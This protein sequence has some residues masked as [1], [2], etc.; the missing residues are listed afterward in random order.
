MEQWIPSLAI[1]AAGQCSPYS[2]APSCRECRGLIKETPQSDHSWDSLVVCNTRHFSCFT[3]LLKSSWMQF[4]SR[5]LW[6][7]SLLSPKLL[8][9]NVSSFRRLIWTLNLNSSTP[10]FSRPHA[11]NFSCNPISFLEN[12]YRLQFS[13]VFLW[14]AFQ[15]PTYSEH[16]FYL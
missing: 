1:D 8:L 13:S 14:L 12:N 4:Q 2:F 5:H 6:S 16:P 11:I 3:H 9:E 10:S 15:A 7:I